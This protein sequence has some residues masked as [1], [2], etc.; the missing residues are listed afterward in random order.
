MCCYST[1]IKSSRCVYIPQ[2]EGVLEDTG[3]EGGEYPLMP[4][5]TGDVELL[6]TA[7]TRAQVLPSGG[8]SEGQ[9]AEE[10][11]TELH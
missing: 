3:E 4:R 5:T 10:F 6:E 1:A 8:G 11:H 9:V 2:Q 7:H